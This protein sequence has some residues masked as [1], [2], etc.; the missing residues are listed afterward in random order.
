M[1]IFTRFNSKNIQDSQIDTL[2]G[3]SKGLLA[4]R[5]VSQ[6]EAEFLQTWLIQ[7]QHAQNPIIL[8]LLGKDK[9]GTD[10]FFRLHHDTARRSAS[11]SKT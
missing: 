8:N 3:L 2:I 11:P 4:D 9:M 7:N 6:A 1:D 5:N 10:L